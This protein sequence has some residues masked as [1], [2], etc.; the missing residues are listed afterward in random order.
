MNHKK[1]MRIIHTFVLQM[2]INSLINNTR[3]LTLVGTSKHSLFVKNDM[4]PFG[5]VIWYIRSLSSKN[6]IYSNICN[7]STSYKRLSDNLP[8]HKSPTTRNR[9]SF[10]SSNR[11][12]LRRLPNIS[13]I[14]FPSFNLPVSLLVELA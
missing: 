13:C 8:E 10:S 3:S 9:P 5:L 7:Y 6:K 1:H 14:A 4:C 2:H 11:T 12:S